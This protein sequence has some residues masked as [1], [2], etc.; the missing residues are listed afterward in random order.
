M[1]P[2]F[3]IRLVC[4]MAAMLP[5]CMLSPLCAQTTNGQTSEPQSWTTTT[6][7]HEVNANPTRTTESHQRS[8]DGSVDTQ[9]V[10][11]L[12]PE[13]QYQPY[14]DIETKSVQVDATT[15]RTTTRTFARDGD[16]QRTLTQV[17]VE[18][19]ESLPAG[20]GKV[21]RT[22]SNADLDG[23]LM[24]VQREVTDIR[25][26]SP[27]LQ[28][29]KTT[30]FRSDGL[31]GMD[32]S[33]EIEQREERSGDHTIAVQTSTLVPDGSGRWQLQERKEST[34]KDDGKERTT[35]EQV[36]RRDAEGNLAPVSRIL[37]KA[38]ENAA[39]EK[40]NTVE[41]YS[42]EAGQDGNLQLIQRATSVMRIGVDGAQA[43]EKRVEQLN[44]ADP[45]TGLLVTTKTLDVVQPGAAGTRATQTVQ[46]RDVNGSFT[47]VFYDTQ[48]SDNVHSVN[49]EIAPPKKAK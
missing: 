48:T 11:R 6:E 42:R 1:Q 39:G 33:L 36:L 47:V 41:T 7:S 27:D 31:G 12:G 44:L 3:S 18:E 30:V 16:G 8:A 13:G 22:T 28:E 19:K 32:P 10:E 21:V 23:H 2:P 49:V 26:A 9:S 5:F 40:N 29:K 25:Q 20:G 14:Y 46:A 35:D 15:V 37:G 24:A 4:W 45:G 34:I 43:S 17:T 38:S